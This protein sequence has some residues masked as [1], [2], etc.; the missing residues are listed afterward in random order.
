MKSP[1]TADGIYPIRAAARLT[2]LSIET[3]RAWE[4]R[5]K[6][7]EPMRRRGQRFYSD[8]DINR[9]SLL[10]RAV[11][12]GYSI[13]Q[14][15]RLSNKELSTLGDRL[16]IS[17]NAASEAPLETILTAIDRFE[18]AR[19]DREL[20]RLAS[21]VSPRD[22]IHNTALPLMRIVGERWH[23][24]RMRIA[25]EHLMSQLLSNLLGAIMRTYSPTDPPAVVMTATL[26]D[27]LHEFGILTA[28][29][30]VAGAGLGI[31][32][33]GA[34][35][36]VKEIVYAAKRSGANVVLLS[37]TNPQDQSRREE[38]LRSIRAAVPK[39]TQVWVGINPASTVLSV[40]GIL[41]LKNFIELERELQRIGGS[42]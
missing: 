16:M 41:V 34:S 5:Y 9:L 18:Y 2:R 33:L 39:E 36:P 15:A 42:L 14:A 35:L 25:Q 19:A 38:Q 4:K 11:D 10:R 3:L 24:Q 37:V 7:V 22:L 40:K 30:L 29:I 12:H 21:L 1:K 31:I 28:A 17:G 23:E 32:H 13:G 6:A 26:D 20:G 27:D 8:A